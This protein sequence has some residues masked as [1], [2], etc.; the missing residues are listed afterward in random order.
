MGMP[1]IHRRWTS[2]D[3]RT[4]IN[5]SPRYWPRYELIG[6]ELIVTPSPRFPH[7]TAAQELW[8]ILKHYLVQQGVGLPMMA[9]ADLE[10]VPENITQPDV[11]VLDPHSVDDTVEMPTWADFKRLFLDTRSLPNFTGLAAQERTV[12]AD[13]R[14]SNSLRDRVDDV[15]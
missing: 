14:P 12:P 6:G 13:N 15:R 2:A 4:L 9:P 10:L 8:F 5:E 7:Q 1:A 3:V 11:F